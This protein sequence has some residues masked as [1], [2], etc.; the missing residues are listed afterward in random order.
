VSSPGELKKELASLRTQ[1]KI[2]EI[3]GTAVAVAFLGAYAGFIVE[4]LAGKGEVTPS[5]QIKQVQP[6]ISQPAVAV[7][8]NQVQHSQ[9]QNL[10]NVQ[11]AP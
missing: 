6:S 5:P 7:G 9:T 3:I 11:R 2:V 8:S 1:L 4:K 10:I